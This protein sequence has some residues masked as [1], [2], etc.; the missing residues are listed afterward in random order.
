MTGKNISDLLSF[1]YSLM[2]CYHTTLQDPIISGT[3]GT[4]HIDGRKL[5]SRKVE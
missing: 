3:T 4:C 1:K 5:L 2:T